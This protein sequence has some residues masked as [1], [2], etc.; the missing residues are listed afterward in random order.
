MES[1]FKS[2]LGSFPNICNFDCLQSY[3]S[4]DY[5]QL[6]Q[7]TVLY[8]NYLNKYLEISKNN[9]LL[10]INPIKKRLIEHQEKINSHIKTQGGNFTCQDQAL[11]ISII[12][13]IFFKTL[14]SFITLS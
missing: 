9:N 11:S 4:K 5:T 10:N 12:F 3:L 8:Q 7:N 14:K 6:K 13:F 1:S 2:K